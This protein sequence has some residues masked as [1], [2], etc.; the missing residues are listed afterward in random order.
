MSYV[1]AC[2]PVG[3]VDLGY[4]MMSNFFGQGSFIILDHDTQYIS[5]AKAPI[6]NIYSSG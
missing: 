2:I 4:R 3:E 5:A 6:S 1:Q